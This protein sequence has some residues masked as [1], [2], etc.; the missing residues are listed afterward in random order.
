MQVGAL[1]SGTTYNVTRDLARH[2]TYPAWADGTPYAV[3]GVSGD[4]R[5]EFNAYDTPRISI[6]TQGATYNAKRRSFA[7]VT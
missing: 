1:V 6:I 7:S 5:I 4:G 3:L 2:V